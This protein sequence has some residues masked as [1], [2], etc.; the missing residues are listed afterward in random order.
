MALKDWGP[1]HGWRYLWDKLRAIRLPKR[2]KK[3]K[4][5]PAPVDSDAIVASAPAP[6]PVVQEPIRHESL[7]P[8]EV[9]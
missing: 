2:Q 4:P 9:K 3:L 5:E 1:G 6:A 7:T 8:E